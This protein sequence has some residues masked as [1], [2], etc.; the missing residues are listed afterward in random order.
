MRPKV[1]QTVARPKS[2]LFFVFSLLIAL[3]ISLSACA[4]RTPEPTSTPT[5]K[6]TSAFT[7]TPSPRW[8]GDKPNPTMTS[9]PTLP[10]PGQAGN[11]ITL[12]IVYRD[13]DRQEPAV[14]E[15]LQFLADETGWVIEVLEFD[16]TFDLLVGMDSGRVSFS[17]MLPLTYIYAQQNEI[18][19]I[20][21]VPKSYNMSAYGTQFIARTDAGFESFFNVD[22]AVNTS[23]ANS[24]LRQF[25]N[26]R[27][28]FLDES[29][30]A[31]YVVPLGY[32]KMAGVS[33]NEP[34]FMLSSTGVIRGVLA[35]GICEFGATYAIMGDP[36]TSSELL[37]EY[38][39]LLEEVNVIWRTD[40]IIP[41]L[42]LSISTKLDGE[43]AGI[44]SNAIMKFSQQPDGPKKLSYAT[45]FNI[46][47]LEP[48]GDEIYE[49]LTDV[50]NASGINLVDFLGN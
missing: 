17:W 36:R 18:A 39:N 34:I 22:E 14:K 23:S 32:L 46:E 13:R 11:P 16:N 15:L 27:P 29:S 19:E 35:G 38:P 6:P 4:H 20:A 3:G 44:L 9:T 42:N 5:P 2:K 41:N 43:I 48:A 49:E 24:A 45:S 7:S 10:P 12:G 21:F 37:E 25:A 30:L 1:S 40:A 8:P 26:T 28:C 31:G 50:V 47:G 33:F